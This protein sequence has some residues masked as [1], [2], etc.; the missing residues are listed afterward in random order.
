MQL[1]RH[2]FGLRWSL[3]VGLFCAL[4]LPFALAAEEEGQLR[5]A[6]AVAPTD[7]VAGLNEV[8]DN[9]FRDRLLEVIS[10][11]ELDPELYE[12][13]GRPVRASMGFQALGENGR[14]LEE[15]LTDEVRTLLLQMGRYAILQYSGP[16][17]IHGIER[18]LQSDPRFALASIEEPGF[19]SAAPNDTWFGAQWGIQVTEQNLPGAW[20]Y[21]DGWAHVGVIDGGLPVLSAPTL[22]PPWTINHSELFQVV[23]KNLSGNIQPGVSNLRDLSEFPPYPEH[24]SHVTGIIAANKNNGAGIAGV[25]SNCSVLFSQADVFPDTITWGTSWLASNG[26]Q[27]INFSG[28]VYRSGW[29]N[30]LGLPCEN[31]YSGTSLPGTPA[32]ICLAL[33][34]AASLES[35]FIASAGN[36]RQSPLDF[37]AS[38]SSVIGVGG[39]DLSG[40][41]WD[42]D[43]FSPDVWD[44]GV[45]GFAG[46]P[47]AYLPLGEE[48]GTN[49]D[50]NLNSRI[51]FSAPS[52]EVLS[53]IPYGLNVYPVPPA[54]TDILNDTNFG[55]SADGLALGNGTSMSA[56]HISGI[57]ALGRSINPLLTRVATYDL[58]K[59]SSS[60]SSSHDD[61]IGWGTPDAE[62]VVEKALGVSGGNQVQIRLTPMFALRRDSDKDRLYT[63][64]PQV[65]MGASLG[66][67]LT[68]PQ[69]CRL[70]NCTG[71]GVMEVPRPY[72]RAPLAE[73]SYVSGYDAFSIY[74]PTFDEV[75]PVSAFWVFTSNKSGSLGFN[76]RPLYRLSFRESCDYRDH[77]YAVTQAEINFYTGTDWCPEPGIQAFHLDGIE[78][79]ILAECPYRDCDGSAWWH[80]QKLYRRHNTA[81]DMSALVL[82]SQDGSSGPF[83]GYGTDVDFGGTGLL[84]W[85][86]PNVD[87]D[88][89]GLIDGLEYLLGTNRLLADSDCDGLSDTTEYPLATLQVAG[90]DP[91]QGPCS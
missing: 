71:T 19:Y 20:D 66:W 44:W 46:C 64:R 59:Q 7:G 26:A 81:H 29:A 62:L 65:A 56:P 84:G 86:Y 30:E 76:L 80:P 82:E 21:V 2:K 27:L 1:A 14:E 72:V 52:R 47:D 53:L 31:P 5:I 74:K 58:L 78:G 79:Y 6:V 10:Q 40:Q 22:N 90:H 16:V 48:C 83:A 8:P 33:A 88:G 60:N 23:S 68:D 55:G 9:Q 32:S 70:P 77:A 34:W 12:H 63:S 41:Y 43:N 3:R 89:D 37:P 13:L 28:G 39:Y 87:T 45:P 73:A 4:G 36:K 51:D 75:K 67:Y 38:D 91:D 85:V 11:P 17:D 35:N 69:R 25:C 18:R 57:V 61:Y 15:G 54:R 50:T 24:G 42:E 49:Y